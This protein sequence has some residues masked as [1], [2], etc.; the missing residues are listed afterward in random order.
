[1]SLSAGLAPPKRLREG[2]VGRFVSLL[3]AFQSFLTLIS[4]MI[5][6]YSKVKKEMQQLPNFYITDNQIND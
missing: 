2:A 3:M 6:I 1:V 5:F 4:D